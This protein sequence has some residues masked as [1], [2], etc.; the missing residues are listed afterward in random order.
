MATIKVDMGAGQNEYPLP[1]GI[2]G[3]EMQAIKRMTGLRAGELFP[4]LAAGDSDVALAFAYTAMRRAG[5]A[6]TW[7]QLLDLPVSQIEL[8]LSDEDEGAD[9]GPPAEGAGAEEDTPP[10]AGDS[11]ETS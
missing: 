10:P 6:V 11:P 9:A 2:T 8:D 1:E 5:N 3:R 7:D 4:A